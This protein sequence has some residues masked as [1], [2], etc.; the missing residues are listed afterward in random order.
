MI[1]STI[2]EYST[3]KKRKNG[4]EANDVLIIS[5]KVI[6][7]FFQFTMNA[8]D[9]KLMPQKVKPFTLGENVEAR[10]R[11]KHHW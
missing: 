3:K 2:G 11:G 1:V 9:I 5:I 10:L 4:H 6:N 7:Y 8:E